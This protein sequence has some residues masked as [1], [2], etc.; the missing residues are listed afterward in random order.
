M[1]RLLLIFV[2]TILLIG[3]NN[4][5][6]YNDFEHIRHWD[7]LDQLEGENTVIYYYSPFCDIC[8]NLEDEVSKLMYE[9]SSDYEVYLVDAGEIFEEGN[10]NFEVQENVP[11]LLIFEDTV[12]QEWIVGSSNVIMFLEEAIKN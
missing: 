9:I 1:K 5:K 7:D 8:I 10:P 4:S 2:I 3:C 11:A 12:F 6:S